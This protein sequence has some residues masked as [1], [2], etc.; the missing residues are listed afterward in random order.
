MS[1]LE[2]AVDALWRAHGRDIADYQNRAYGRTPAADDLV[3]DGNPDN[4]DDLPF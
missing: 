2:R 4:P 1:I 3:P